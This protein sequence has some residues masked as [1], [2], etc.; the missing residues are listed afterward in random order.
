LCICKKTRKMGCFVNKNDK[1]MSLYS[2]THKFY[3]ITLKLLQYV[4]Q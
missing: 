4:Y 3:V 2:F 1:Y